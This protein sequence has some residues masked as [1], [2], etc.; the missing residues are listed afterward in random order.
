MHC[1]AGYGKK[2]VARYRPVTGWYISET[3]YTK[4]SKG[5]K[6]EQSERLRYL[7]RAFSEERPELAGVGTGGNEEELRTALRSMM[8][9]RPPRP[10]D[11][12]TKRV[13]DEYLRA[14]AEEKGIVDWKGIPDVRETLGLEGPAATKISLWR[15]DITRLR[16]GA[17]VNAANPGMTGCWVP[18][19]SCI[20]NCIHTY[21][22][23][24]LREE[25]A[26]RMEAYQKRHPGA[27]WPTAVPMLTPGYCLPAEHVVH[28]V[29]PVVDGPLR[30][31]HARDLRDCYLRTLDLCAE[32]GIRSVAF[33]CISTGVYRFP[34]D[35]AA[36]LAAET[37]A[38]WLEDTPEAV[39]RVVFDVFSERDETLYR[40]AL[41][42]ALG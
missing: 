28:I 9:V 33:C 12:E 3:N 25:C 30:E 11:P 42:H 22:G 18:M 41:A 13:Q 16:I 7:V 23:T 32:E 6:M 39:D 15:G 4:D 26:L 29:G 21:A 40:E 8:N 17:I 31:S 38:G 36:E 14:R 34:A 20:D 1:M 27:G 19:H 24:E 37:V 10:L 2:T 5:A 35:L